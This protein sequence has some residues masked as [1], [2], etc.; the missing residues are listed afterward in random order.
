VTALLSHAT[1]DGLVDLVAVARWV[2]GDDVDLTEAEQK[3][4]IHSARAAGHS[5]DRISK[6]LHTADR[7]VKA[8]LEL[9]APRDSRGRPLI[10][11]N[12]L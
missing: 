6:R 10:V 11:N 5:I 7:N 2:K 9:P 12:N 3:V 8:V 4:A 1:K